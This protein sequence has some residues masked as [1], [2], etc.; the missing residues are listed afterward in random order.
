M[1]QFGCHAGQVVSPDLCGKKSTNCIAGQHKSLWN[2]RSKAIFAWEWKS[3]KIVMSL[4]LFWD[5]QTINFRQNMILRPVSHIKHTETATHR[6][7][8][9]RTQRMSLCTTFFHSRR[10]QLVLSCLQWYSG[11]WVEERQRFHLKRRRS[12]SNYLLTRTTTRTISA[13]RSLFYPSCLA[14]YST[15]GTCH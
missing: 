1:L 15:K 3:F 12:W 7:I 11:I 6:E 13:I 8:I 14:R 2:V 10:V 4:R 5:W 9:W